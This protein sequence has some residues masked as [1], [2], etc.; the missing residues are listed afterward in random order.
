MSAPTFAFISAKGGSGATTI[1]AELAKCMR[2]K[3][4]VAVVDGDLSGRRNMAILFDAVRA[5]DATH[6]ASSVGVT[7][8]AAGITL[9]ELAPTYDSAF[10]I[11]FDDVEHLAASLSKTGCVLADV[12]IPFAAP[13]RPFVVRA[14]RFVVVAEPTLLGI[15]SARTMISELK[16]FG[17]PLT[18]IVMISNCRDG[19]PAATRSEIERGLEVKLL[20]E[21]PQTSDRNYAK[22]LAALE[23]VIGAISEEPEVP[24]CTHRLKDSSKIAASS[25][26]R[27]CA[28]T[29]R[30]SRSP[31]HDSN[32]H[33]KGGHAV[34][35]RERLKL[36]IHEALSQKVN[37]IEA[38]A[39]HR[40]RRN[41]RKL[42]VKIDE[43][44]QQTLR[45]QKPQRSDG[46]RNRAD[47][48][49]DRERIARPWPARRS[50]GRSGGNGNHGKR[51]E[52]RVH[53]ARR[54]NRTDRKAL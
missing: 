38:S 47:S 54:K 18:R 39:A 35:P 14:T 33:P 28:R 23:R 46:R 12:P 42:R 5:L 45:R 1:C 24:R 31:S 53:R 25:R 26:A 10:T 30:R 16:R 22:A 11:N 2:G 21:L 44:A 32:G 29:L 49:R 15:A 3:S 19:N 9:A 41:S 8:P 43:A 50:H 34:E 6:D 17:V 27:Q 52:N 40:T 36:D 13:V 48:R 4:P 37:L 51:S 20:G 7:Q